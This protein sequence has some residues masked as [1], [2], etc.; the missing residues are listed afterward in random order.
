MGGS[1]EGEVKNKAI[2]V[3][4]RWATTMALQAVM[5]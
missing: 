3:I 5:L 2:V 4:R 1:A